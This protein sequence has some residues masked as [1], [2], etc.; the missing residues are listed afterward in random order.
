MPKI[1]S[2]TPVHTAP[3]VTPMLGITLGDPAGIGVEV[4]LKALTEGNAPS[5]CRLLL[6]GEGVQ[7]AAQMGFAKPGHELH[8]IRDASQARWEAG[9]INVLDM[10]VLTSPLPPGQRDARGGEAAFKA[11]EW[12]IHL[13]QVGVLAG[14]VTAPLNKDALHQAGHRFDG[15][16][17]ILGHF[18][19]QIPTFMLLSS[20]KLKIVH[21]STHCSLR[22]ACDR[23]KTP[24]ILEAIRVMD[25]HLRKIGQSQRRIGVAGL[26]PHAGENGLFGTEEVEEIL[27]AIEAA[28]AQ[29]IDAQG[30]IPPDSL[31]LRAYRGAFDAIVAMYHDQGHI[32]QKLVAFEEAVNVTLGLPLIRTAV[33]HGTAFDIAG[34]GKADPTNM[35]NAIRYALRMAQGEPGGHG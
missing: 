3:P 19:G 17:E 30:P 16:T 1:Q 35:V 9:V 13:T 7:V 21:V 6:I 26:N 12:G 25:I 11:L 10:G 20:P 5:G 24:R 32:P 15:H 34:Q 31:Y 33:D 29:G 8:I 2:K 18:C 27:P 14:I 28:R 22:Q 4:S 23:V